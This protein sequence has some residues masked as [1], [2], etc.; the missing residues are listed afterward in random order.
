MRQRHGKAPVSASTLLL[1]PHLS[2]LLS[3]DLIKLSLL[4]I[5]LSL[6]RLDPPLNLRVL[7]FPRLHLITDQSA[8]EESDSGTDTGSG[9][10]VS[11]RAADDR[12]QPRAGRRPD[13][14]AFLSG[15]KGLGAAERKTRQCH[16]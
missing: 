5:D 6:L 16:C 9:A 15:R 7:L 11:R 12:A 8:A 13:D 1:A 3:F 10:G 2:G 14:C 4:P